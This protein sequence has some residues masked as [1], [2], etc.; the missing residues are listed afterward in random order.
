[1]ELDAT[2]F[3]PQKD[4]QCGPAALATALG[5]SG[6]TV[7]PES[8]VPL[9]YLPKRRGSLQ[10]EML[11]APRRYGRLAYPIARNLDAIL[12][13][14]DAGRPVLVL[15]NYGI[16][17]LPRWHYA[18]V[19]GYDATADSL[20]LRSGTTRRQV[21]SARHFML[22]WDNGGRWAMV[23]L[24][25]GELPALPSATAYLE[26]AASF[27]HGASPGDARRAFDAA[28]QRWPMEP[29]AWIGRGTAEYRAGSLPEAA[30]DYL[31]ALRLD[32]S[33]IGA[34]N[35]LAMTLLDMG[36]RDQAREQLDHIRDTDLTASLRDAVLDTRR[37]LATPGTANT[38][39]ATA[40]ACGGY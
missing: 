23:L 20:L 12:A 24:R 19:V 9:V 21:L 7:T 3:F 36:C 29:V 1:V 11:A 4:Y 15:H 6:S 39:S 25:P 31:A 30:Q 2:P 27:E 5:A 13:E 40:A 16:P 17:L 28:V 10:V 18:V 22:A 32:S 37:R 14:L 35:N 38:A 33:N 26:A 34:R 8:L